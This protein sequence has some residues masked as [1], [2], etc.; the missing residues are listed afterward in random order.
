MDIRII[1]SLAFVGT[2]IIV[3]LEYGWDNDHFEIAGW[4]G[5]STSIIVKTKRHILRWEQTAFDRPTE[6]EQDAIQ[7]SSDM[8]VHCV[9]IPRACVDY[10][11]YIVAFDA[12][13]RRTGTLP[14][15]INNV[16]K[17]VR[18][19]RVPEG[20]GDAFTGGGSILWSPTVRLVTTNEERPH[21]QNPVA[22]EGRHAVVLYWDWEDNFAHTFYAVARMLTIYKDN[23]M[24]LNNTADVLIPL[25]SEGAAVPSYVRRLLGI[26]PHK[27]IMSV[28]EAI[29]NG[30]ACYDRMHFCS[31]DSTDPPSLNPVAI[32]E[33]GQLVKGKYLGVDTA[34]SGDSLTLAASDGSLRPPR[35]F[36]RTNPLVVTIVNRPSRGI[37]NAEELMAVCNNSTLAEYLSCN[38]HNFGAEWVTD[39][40]IAH[41]TDVLIGQHGAA[42]TNM[43]FLKPYSH[44]VEVR[45]CEYPAWLDGHFKTVSERAG[46]ILRFWIAYSQ[47]EH[48]K[49]GP[50]EAMNI[51]ES[52]VYARDRSVLWPATAFIATLENILQVERDGKFSNLYHIT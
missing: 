10:N 41:T 9:I 21:L 48:C 14:D 30:A 40:R 17:R 29:N 19:V 15:Y 5:K 49:P 16:R 28:Q 24:L 31:V 35:E 37:L 50:M 27:E 1:L 26:L 2:I 43:L 45:P 18:N 39:L 33:V 42:L 47:R 23:N 46:F 3:L 38:L 4:G 34:I 51:G 32:F 52:S 25:T 22:S 6:E 11:N 13:Y 8:S 36:S 7:R 44:V 20:N 12:S